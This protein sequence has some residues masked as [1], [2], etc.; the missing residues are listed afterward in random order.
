MGHLIGGLL[1]N[2]SPFG[3]IMGKCLLIIGA[4]ILFAVFCLPVVTIGPALAALYDCMLKSLRT[5]GYVSPFRLFW[6]GFR[7]NFRQAVVCFAGFAVLL[8][9]LVLDLRFCSSRGGVWK[10]FQYALWALLFLEAVMAVYLVPVMAA[11]RDTIPHLLRNALFFAARKPLKILPALALYVLPAA[12]TVLD[13]RMR[14]LYGFLW[15]T[16]LAGL[17]VW[18]ESRLLIRDFEEFLPRR[19][20]REEGSMPSRP[21]EPSPRAVLKEM[22]K[23]DQ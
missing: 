19:E 4:N 16:C 10:V 9:V 21:A 12:V 18:L 20:D 11:F 15:V 7:M 5:E 2:D 6:E 23:L 13:V 8:A 22:K 14:P 3:R 17:I 1:D